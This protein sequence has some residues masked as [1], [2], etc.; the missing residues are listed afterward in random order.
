VDPRFVAQTTAAA[1][2]AEAAE[3]AGAYS[4]A[5]GGAVSLDAFL[6]NLGQPVLG[7]GDERSVDES[8]G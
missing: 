7:Q 3:A 1:A 6:A 5:R 2:A 4:S 8:A